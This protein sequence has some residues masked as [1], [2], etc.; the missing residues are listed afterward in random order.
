MQPLQIEDLYAQTAEMA[1]AEKERMH[2]IAPEIAEKISS[3]QKNISLSAV[4]MV[5]ITLIAAM[6][7]KQ[8]FLSDA[9]TNAPVKLKNASPA[10]D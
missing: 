2:A 5:K 4:A 9:K 3:A 7:R 8:A 6:P 1:F 10:K